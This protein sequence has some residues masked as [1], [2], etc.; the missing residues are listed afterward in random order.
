MAGSGS[1]ALSFVAEPGLTV[2]LVGPSS[3][4][5]STAL[6]LIPRLLNPRAAP[7]AS[8]APTSAP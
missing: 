4:G 3:A 7:S 5:K 2:A 8:T 1:T 6:S